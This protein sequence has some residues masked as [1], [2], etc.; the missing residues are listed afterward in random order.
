MEYLN[1]GDF[2]FHLQR[3]IRFNEET[4]KFYAA[5]LYLA[6][7][8]MHKNKYLYRDIKPENTMFDNRGYLKVVDLGMAKDK[9]DS[10]NKTYTVC[11][12]NEYLR[13]K[14]FNK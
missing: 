9:L 3:K 12:T 10:N 6:L 2:F 1:G 13:K 4:A 14:H 8:Y 11:G 5:Q 7:E